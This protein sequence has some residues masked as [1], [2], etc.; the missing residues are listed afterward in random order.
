MIG[1]LNHDGSALNNKQSVL[2]HDYD[3][4]LLNSAGTVLIHDGSVL[5]H[6][7]SVLNL[8]GCVLNCHGII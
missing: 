3:G 1:V 7:R 2:N 5:N 8:D 4:N 6:Y